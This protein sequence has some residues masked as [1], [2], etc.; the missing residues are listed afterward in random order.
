[1]IMLRRELTG[2]LKS[3]SC[4]EVAW[5]ELRSRGVKLELENIANKG[6]FVEAQCFADDRCIQYTNNPIIG[7]LVY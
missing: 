3:D 5:N 2:A 7:L 6:R 4:R 1:M